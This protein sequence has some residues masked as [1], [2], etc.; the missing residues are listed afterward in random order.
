MHS[1]GENKMRLAVLWTFTTVAAAMFLLAG[2]LKLAGVPMEVQLFDAI[3][4]G[5]WFRYLTGMLEIG[6]AVGLFV[7]AAAP[8]AALIL[9]TVMIGAIVTHLFIVGGSPLA[10]IVLFTIALAIALLRRDEIRSRLRVA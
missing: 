8:F 3:G 2:G 4:V 9:A 10:P 1:K 5:Q 7:P 6:G